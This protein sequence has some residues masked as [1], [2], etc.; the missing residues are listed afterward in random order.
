MRNVLVM[1]GKGVSGVSYADMGIRDSSCIG[2]P[3]EHI[4]PKGFESPHPTKP[5]QETVAVFLPKKC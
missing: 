3:L 1:V 4:T 2:T 5:L